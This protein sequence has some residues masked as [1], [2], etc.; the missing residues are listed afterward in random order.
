MKDLNTNIIDDPISNDEATNLATTPLIQPSKQGTL[1]AKSAPDLSTQASL[2]TLEPSSNVQHPM[3]S[4]DHLSQSSTSRIRSI[5]RRG[6]NLSTET[7][8]KNDHLRPGSVSPN[9]SM[10]DA[11]GK[12]RKSAGTSPASLNRINS[13]YVSTRQFEINE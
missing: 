7:D 10:T 9:P 1:P 13:R 4:D 2:I 5:F 8:G 12:I 6:R 11:L 3:A